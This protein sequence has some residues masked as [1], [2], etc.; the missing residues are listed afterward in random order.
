MS[1][2]GY[3]DR[4]ALKSWADRLVSKGEFPRLIRQLILETTTDIST[5]GMPA[6]DGVAAGG[7]DGSVRTE[8]GNAWVPGG[9]SVWELSV[10]RSPGVK[11][12]KDYEKRDSTPDGTQ[13]TETTYVEAILRPWTTRDAWA[14]NKTA[15]GTWN[16]VR[17]L[18]LD[19]IEAWLQSA[20]V[21]W[22]WLS[23]EFGL[24][25]FGL[26]TGRSWWATWSSQTTPE[27]SPDLVLAG[28][29]EQFKGLL[30]HLNPGI[31]TIGGPSSNEVCAFI[32]AAAAKKDL[33]GEGQFLARLALVDDLTAWRR[34]LESRSPLIL[35]ALDPSFA[36]EVPPD[37]IHTVLVP[38][39]AGTKAN[40]CLTN[41]DAGEVS[42]ALRIA[43]MSND[44]A[45]ELA[46]LARRSLTALRRRLARKPALVRPTWASG[47]IPRAVR[48]MLMLGCWVDDNDGDRQMAEAL[49]GM[50]YE[51]FHAECLGLSS[52]DDPFL[53]I[54]GSTWHLVSAVD[55]WMLLTASLTI[56]D[57][58]RLESAVLNVIGEVDPALQLPE[59]ARWWRASLDGKQRVYS[60]D[61]R[62]GLSETLALLGTYGGVNIGGSLSG[63]GWVGRIVWQLLEAANGDATGHGWQSLASMLPLL[64]EAAPDQVADAVTKAATQRNAVLATMFATP[65]AN[66]LFAGSSHVHLL[67]ALEVLAWSEPHFGQS[68]DL[69]ARLDRLDPGGRTGNRPA[70]SLSR[71]F[72]PWHPEATVS[73]ERRLKVLDAVR[74]RY[75]D[76][77]W[78]LL[79]SLLPT[80]HAT[81]FPTSA[82]KYRDW[83]PSQIAV[84]RVEY[85]EFI[86]EILRRLIDDAGSFVPHWTEL[87]DRYDHLPPQGREA[88]LSALT[89]LRASNDVDDTGRT[90]IWESLH[91]LAGHHR[92]FSTASWA[93]PEDELARLD[94]AASEFTPSTASARNALLFDGWSPHLGDVSLREDHEA[95]QTVLLE[96]RAQALSQIVTE[97]G[98]SAAL[99]VA[100]RVKLPGAVGYALGAGAQPFDDEVFGLLS[101]SSASDVEMAFAYFHRRFQSEGWTWVRGLLARHCN[102][103]ADQR[104]QLLLAIRDVPTSWE[105]AAKDPDVNTAYW[106]RFSGVGLGHNF[107]HVEF[108]IRSLIG[109]DRFVDALRVIQDYSS[110]GAVEGVLRANLIATALDCLL[111]DQDRMDSSDLYRHDFDDLFGVLETHV[112][113]LGA[114][115]VAALEWAY[116]GAL[117]LEPSVPTLSRQL[118]N[119][120]SFFVTLIGYIYGGA[121]ETVQSPSP[122]DSARHT[123]IA[124]N[125]Y[126][127]LKAWHEPPGLVDGVM[128]AEL[129]R[130]WINEASHELA[131]SG[132]LHHGMEHLGEV[133]IHTPSGPDELW[134]GEVVRDILEEKQDEDIETGIYLAIVNGRG[135]TGRALDEGG[136]KEDALAAKYEEDAARVSD[137]APRAAAVL[138]RVAESYRQDARR[139]DAA[140][141]RYRAGLM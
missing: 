65:D 100:R 58:K 49:S 141:E 127:L 64:A 93:L 102:A 22:A 53:A 38:T 80:A 118:A 15:T 107:S 124:G 126:N 117:G 2:P 16:E 125:A 13:L 30:E 54:V 103:P 44:R 29:D 123:R 51:D 25:P 132:W 67:W 3:V 5:L 47:A 48:A 41:L 72:C 26:R 33:D 84:S 91:K 92:E 134:P 78:P 18:G 61:L 52:C 120:P 36:T 111:Q 104:A 112:D 39:V 85:L 129:L 105:V 17:A 99:N 79:V 139:N 56:D 57:F 110:R 76:I 128:S 82:P 74:R 114:D 133:L 71:I 45:D 88:F 7:W 101:S 73:P 46:R 62:K 10:D 11:A 136:A 43:G 96:R 14:K 60:A 28:R 4:Q 108:V 12:D 27:I 95:F 23:E 97:E 24:T 19:D 98:F 75:P 137:D 90:T 9:Y 121:D 6:G 135:V 115:R 1:R 32:A 131:V 138:R 106:R 63:P 113:A 86:L 31:V 69:L 68:I 35:V 70:A 87:I 89:V 8:K 50:S 66:P 119:T 122:E 109:A 40:L 55:A 37:C 81:H 130:K 116:L 94:E 34:L 20:P 83:K 42:S 59:E 21:T 140:A 77:A